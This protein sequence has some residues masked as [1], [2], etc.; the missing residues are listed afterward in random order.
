MTVF[1]H[2]NLKTH[3]SIYMLS[4][5]SK[6]QGSSEMPSELAAGDERLNRKYKE[7]EM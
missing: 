2:C 6:T 5:M 1:K 7:T 4:D 3:L